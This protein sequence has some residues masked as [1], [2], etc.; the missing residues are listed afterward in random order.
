MRLH[1]IYLVK[2]LKLFQKDTPGLVTF[3][4]NLPRMPTTPP[5]FKNQP[6]LGWDSSRR[7]PQGTQLEN[8]TTAAF[9]CC[10]VGKLICRA[11]EG[12]CLQVPLS[13]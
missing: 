6:P 13:C 5:P 9:I 4:W 2:D 11:E 12:E 7:F 10:P 3:V 8:S 1:A